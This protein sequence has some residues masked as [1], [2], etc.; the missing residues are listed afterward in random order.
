[1]RG[2]ASIA[3]AD[4]QVKPAKGERSKPPTDEERAALRLAKEQEKLA[5]A[6]AKNAGNAIGPD[7]LK[8]RQEAAAAVGPKANAAASGSGSSQDTVRDS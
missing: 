8:A 1:M 3:N 5:K 7:E 2:H 4:F 6:Q